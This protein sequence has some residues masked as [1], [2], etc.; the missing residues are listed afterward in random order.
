MSEP[1]VL[2]TPAEMTAWTKSMVKAGKTIGFVPTMGALHTGHRSLIERARKENDAVV[3][4]IFV[5]PTQFGPNED[6]TKYP[7]TF[8]SDKKICGDAGTD[9][10]F[11]PEPATMYD[12]DAR[13]FVEVGGLADNL[14]GLSRPGHFR[15]VATVVTKLFTIVRPDRAY[16]GQKD[17][18][19]LRII[20][21]MTRDLNLGCQIIGCPI[22]READGLAMSSRNRY[23]SP[24]ERQHAL[25]LNQVLKHVEKRVAAGERD[26][27]KLIGEMAE[28]IEGVPDAEIDYVAIVDVNTLEDIKTIEGE[29]LAAL[30]VK[31]GATRL[32]DNTRLLAH[33]G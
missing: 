6:F 19:Q 12:K 26:A 3:V 32:I 16:F 14:C 9:A 7:R 21:V 27:M 15:G 22:V 8:D 20:E 28:Q 29:A 25:T 2:K 1:V 4:S 31:I 5:N 13:T 30:A 17:A 33:R 23:L 18:Q 11:N 10:I 24:E